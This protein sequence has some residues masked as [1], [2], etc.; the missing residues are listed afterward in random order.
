MTFITWIKNALAGS[1]N[2]AWETK[3]TV[4]F[5][6]AKIQTDCEYSPTRELLWEN[7]SGISIQ[8]TS[9]GPWIYDFWWHFTSTNGEELLLF[10]MEAKGEKA[11]FEYLLDTYPDFDKENFTKAISS[12]E[13]KAFLLWGQ[14]SK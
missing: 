1:Y 12:T 5:D 8:T 11:L 13:D 7:V 10:P 3:I 6:E 4:D 9:E 2:A 14:E